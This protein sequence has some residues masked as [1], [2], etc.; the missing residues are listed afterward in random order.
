MSPS[1][2]QASMRSNQLTSSTITTRSNDKFFQILTTLIFRPLNIQNNQ[3]TFFHHQATYNAKNE[4]QVDIESFADSDWA[5]CKTTRK[6]TSG[7]ITSCWGTPLLHI[8]RTQSTIA[9]LPRKL[10]STQWDSRQSRL[11]T[12]NG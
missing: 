6:S 1:P 3:T 2:R 7:T 9:L 5:G 4:I 10:N 8:S 11:N 12:F